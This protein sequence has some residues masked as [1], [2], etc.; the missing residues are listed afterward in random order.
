MA[1]EGLR[2]LRRL[3][4]VKAGR[5][6]SREARRRPIPEASMVERSHTAGWLP[7]L[8]YAPL[9]KPG[10]KAADWFAPKADGAM[11]EDC[12]EISLELPGVAA[13][14]IAVSVQD[15]ALTIQG[16]KRFDHEE[17][18]RTYFFSEREYGAFQRSFR[19]PP[20]AAKDRVDAAFKNGVLTVR[21][22]K[23]Q[24]STV[25]GLRVPVRTE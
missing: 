17:S 18:G 15:G 16:E 20:D 13:D 19:L 24:P 9:R 12:Y 22:A 11:A 10:Q 6:R 5:A 23:L 25:E 2:S 1:T 3:T 7:P 21:I 8:V 14:D 4:P